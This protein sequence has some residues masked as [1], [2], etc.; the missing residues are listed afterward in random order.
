MS[1]V[2][3][4]EIGVSESAS[5]V[6]R[7]LLYELHGTL[8]ELEWQSKFLALESA[9]PPVGAHLVT[10]RWGNLY[11]HHGVYVGG[12]EVIHYGGFSGGGSDAVERVS[13]LDFSQYS[14]EKSPGFMVIHHPESS[15]SGEEAKQRAERRIGEDEYN[16]ISNNCEHFANW[17]TTGES[18]STQSRV[19]DFR[20]MGTRLAVKLEGLSFSMNGRKGF[21]SASLF[22]S[23]LEEVIKEEAG[24][25]VRYRD[26]ADSALY[27]AEEN[28]RASG[29][30][31]EQSER[32]RKDFSDAVYSKMMRI[33]GELDAIFDDFDS[34]R[35]KGDV[36]SMYDETNAALRKMGGFEDV[37]TPS[38]LR[39]LLGKKG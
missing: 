24:G 23:T 27:K 35:E 14:D 3:P 39:D 34:S 28:L 13:L 37:L 16:L 31:W 5:E 17:C 20:G 19:I 10:P 32:I 36:D 33:K 4:D 12:F 11:T 25:V 7:E 1:Y 9:E 26:A 18:V 2:G 8:R 21:E 6:W 22:L 30:L 38:Q 15:V 29:F